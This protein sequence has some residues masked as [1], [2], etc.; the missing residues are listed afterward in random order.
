MLER[1]G[2]PAA[3]SFLVGALSTML[4]EDGWECSSLLSELED[5]SHWHFKSSSSMDGWIFAGKAAVVDVTPYLTRRNGEG[6][7]TVDAS[8]F[9]TYH[10][11]MVLELEEALDLN[12]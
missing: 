2:E 9:I 7:L 10:L 8:T 11:S 5:D 3:R 12:G 1:S 6:V 4:D